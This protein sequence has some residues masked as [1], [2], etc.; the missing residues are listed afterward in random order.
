MERFTRG[1]SI[2]LVRLHYLEDGTGTV[3]VSEL[4]AG[5]QLY[6]ESRKQN[7]RNQKIIGALLAFILIFIGVLST[8][9]FMV[10][11]L[12]KETKAETS[13]VM[14]AGPSSL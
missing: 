12:T 5:A 10:V 14:K 6:T 13:G 8:M 1:S 3:D 9:T 2:S 11:E 4:T 7:S